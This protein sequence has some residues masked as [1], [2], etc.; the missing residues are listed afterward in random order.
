MGRGA[1]AQLLFDGSRRWGRGEVRFALVALD[2]A[3]GPGFEIDGGALGGLEKG[4]VVLLSVSDTSASLLRGG[5]TDVE[6]LGRRT[7][8]RVFHETFCNH[9][10]ED[11]R[12]G[13]ALGQL[14]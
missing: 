8:F 4:V 7:V 13:V 10:F 12:K 14:W 6:F 11:R 2:H 3:Y 9:V 1:F 5:G